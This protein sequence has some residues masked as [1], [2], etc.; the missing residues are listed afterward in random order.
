M[1]ASKAKKILTVDDDEDIRSSIC[2]RLEL[3][4]F[5]TVWAKNGRVALEYMR[6]T[7]DTDLPDLI[8]LDFMMPIMNGQ[9][10]CK[11]K[12]KI[13]RLAHIP[14][15]MM[16]ASG[17]LVNVMDKIDSNA[18]GYM[19]K[20]MDD[21]TIV[22]MVRHFLN[23]MPERSPELTEPVTTNPEILNETLGINPEAV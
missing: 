23:L 19:S 7:P 2:D 9:E 12:A 11:E 17:N 16:T 10:F 14:V 21:T 5:E 20:P 4:G 15:V 3:E 8:L 13:E 18:N 1:C 22:N 6:A